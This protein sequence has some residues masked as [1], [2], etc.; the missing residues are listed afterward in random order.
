MHTMDTAP[1]D[2]PILLYGESCWYE[3]HWWDELK[4]WQPI[5]LDYHGCGCCGADPPVPEGWLPL[6]STEI[7]E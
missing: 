5:R 1:K 6:P 2:K 4:R 3:G 7:T